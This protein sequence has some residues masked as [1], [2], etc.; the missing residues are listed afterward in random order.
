[1]KTPKK[2]LSE[3]TSITKIYEM[4][5]NET[6]ELIMYSEYRGTQNGKDWWIMYR[7]TMA[8]I[9]SGKLTYSAVRVYM[10]IT[11]RADWRGVLSTTQTAIAKEIGISRQAVN[12]AIEELKHYDL[13]REARENGQTVYIVNPAYA[14]LGKDKKRR[15]AVFNELPCVENY[16]RIDSEEYVA[17]IS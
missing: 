6:G 2:T 7:T 16:V 8:F 14:T 1:M 10:H 9:A 11:A 12:K 15:L 17:T 4:V 3:S 5:D 13:I